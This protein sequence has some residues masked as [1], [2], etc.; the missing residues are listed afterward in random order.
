MNAFIWKLFFLLSITV[1]ITMS[2]SKQ[3]DPESRRKQIVTY[4]K[5]ISD[6]NAKIALLQRELEDD[7][8]QALADI[9]LVP[10]KVKE[11]VPERFEH[12]FEAGGTLEA[13]NEAFISPETGGRIKQILVREGQFVT[14]GTVLARLNTE[15]SDYG[16]AEVRTQL[17]LATT[18]FRKQEELW[19]QKIGSEIE[20]LQAKSNKEALENR[21]KTMQAQIDMATIKAPVSGMIDRIMQKEGELAAPGMMLIRLINLQEMYV[22][23]DVAETY[24]P[25]LQRGDDVS[26]RF[27]T[28]PGLQINAP[29]DLIGHSIEP[30]NRTVKVR[31]K[32]KNTPDSKLKPNMLA[33]LKFKDFEQEDALLVPAICIKL[34]TKGA[35]LYRVK[36]DGAKRLAEKV[37]VKT[38]KVTEGITLIKEGLA[39]GDKV[40]VEGYNMVT[41]GS[42]IRL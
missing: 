25:V 10:V 5:Q 23:A 2:C 22:N 7:S 8:L 41:N 6:L 31:I 21:L 34:D 12:F 11:M 1:F 42:E 19:R 39:A 35:Y 15:A 17:D 24:L 26:I 13:V 14:K 4:Q 16:M 27:P 29:I 3:E 32:V 40:I 28:W 18:V 37:Y 30:Q 33:M 20:Y 38:G 36:E 9:N